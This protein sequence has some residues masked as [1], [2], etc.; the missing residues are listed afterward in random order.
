VSLLPT[1]PGK[2]FGRPLQQLALPLAYLRRM[3]PTFCPELVHRPALLHHFQCHHSSA[4][5]A[6]L[7][8]LHRHGTSLLPI[9]PFRL[10][11][12]TYSLVHFSGSIINDWL[13]LICDRWNQTVFRTSLVF[14]H[15][16][17]ARAL[18]CRLHN[19][20]QGGHAAHDR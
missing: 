8:T 19:T 20:L 7:P 17:N 15:Q 18:A 11:E 13:C 9:E 10:P 4:L 6:M 2:Q 3:D 16:G 12:L 1:V 14:F 5:G